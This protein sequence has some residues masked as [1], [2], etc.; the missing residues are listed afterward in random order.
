MNMGRILAVDTVSIMGND[1]K[2]ARGLTPN[3]P[4]YYFLPL[5]NCTMAEIKKTRPIGGLH[6]PGV[7][8]SSAVLDPYATI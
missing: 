7:P 1:W 2:Y 5:T 6:F 4:D 8:P 3:T